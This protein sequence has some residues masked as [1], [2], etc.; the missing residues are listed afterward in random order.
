MTA[1]SVTGL[2]TIASNAVADAARAGVVFG[3]TSAI[4][5]FVVL[6]HFGPEVNPEAPGV[7]T[8][9]PAAAP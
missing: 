5:P 9:Q 2:K 6:R 1:Q 7:G 3:N 8:K 4:E